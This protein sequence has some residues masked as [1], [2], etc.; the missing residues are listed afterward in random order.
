MKRDQLVGWSIALVGALAVVF[1]CRVLGALDLPRFNLEHTRIADLDP[2][3]RRMLA[4]LD[5]D[6][7]ATFCV[8]A[9]DK[10]PSSER[11][12][13]REVTRLLERMH[14][15]RDASTT[16]CSILTSERTWAIGSRAKASRR[17][18]CAK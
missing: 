7:L 4:E 14:G 3:T 1:L 9:R 15:P 12:L 11:R 5:S 17:S 18:R 8:S 13:E 6:V 2:R 10:L 16:K